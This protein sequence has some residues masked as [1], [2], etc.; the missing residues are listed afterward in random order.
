MKYQYFEFRLFLEM[1]KTNIWQCWGKRG[2][3]L[4]TVEWYRGWP[5][6]VFFPA[7][8]TLWSSG[9]LSDVKDFLDKVNREHKEKK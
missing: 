9:C 4:G 3:F 7:S 5:Q 2:D 8:E 6:Y 1:P